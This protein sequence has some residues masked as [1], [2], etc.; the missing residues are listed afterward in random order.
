MARTGNRLTLFTALISL[1]ILSAGDVTGAGADSLPTRRL[2]DAERRLKSRIIRKIELPKG[3]YHEG[4]FLDGKELWV[5]NGKGGNI[6]V[7]DLD[8]GR[9]KR[10]IT[11][12]A[13]FTEG[14]TTSGG[15]TFVTDWEEKRLYRI[16]MDGGRMMAHDSV[17]FSPAYP[18]GVVWD[19]RDLFVIKWTRGFGTRFE[20][21]RLD[22]K[23][24]NVLEKIDIQRIQEP[25]HIA[26]DGASLWIT[27]WYNRRVYRIDKAGWKITGY[28]RSPVPRTTGIAWDGKRFWLTGT[29]GGLYQVEVVSN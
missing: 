28:F 14:I 19:G 23:T 8:S 20:L 12:V 18:A 27:S 26:W 10:E 15:D 2:I 6:W 13:G 3:G 11:P 24:L 4:L 25:A 1:S 21:L 16:T 7:I 5:A 29:Y 9:L 22:S 17:S